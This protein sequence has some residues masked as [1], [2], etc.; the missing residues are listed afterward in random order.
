M[1][2]MS[3]IYD[4]ATAPSKFPY[5]WGKLDFL[6]HQCTIYSMYVLITFTCDRFSFSW[7]VILAC[8]LSLTIKHILIQLFR[9]DYSSLWNV[10]CFSVGFPSCILAEFQFRILGFVTKNPCWRGFS[11]HLT[12]CCALCSFL[13]SSSYFRTT[14]FIHYFVPFLIL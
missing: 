8:E 14:W 9:T 5:I 11:A 2:R 4:F 6:F 7:W 13:F 1:G 12:H 3:V 10:D